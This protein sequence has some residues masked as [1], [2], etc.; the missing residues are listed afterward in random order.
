[1]NLTHSQTARILRELSVLLHAGIPV[2]EGFFLLAAEEQGALQQL[3]QSLAAEL[4]QGTPLPEALARSG[5]FPRQVSAMTAIGQATGRMEETLAS[6]A[7]YYEERHRTSRRIRQALGYPAAIGALMLVVMGVLLI[8]VLPVFDEVYA[9]L[10]S[11]LTGIAAGLLYFGQLLEAALPAL[12]VI[13]LGIIALVRFCRPL[14]ESISGWF[15][16]RFGDRWVFRKNN[17]ARFAQAMALGLGSGLPLE[18]AAVLSRELLEDIPGA[19]RRCR[20]CTDALQ[21]GAALAD[22]MEAGSLLPPHHC[23]MLAVG[24]QSGSGDRVMQQIAAQM[25][26]TARE[27]LEDA[28]GKIEPAMVLLT[29]LMVGLLLLTVM[30]PLLNILSA[31]G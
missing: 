26:E 11:R 12:L 1:M 28:V 4:D 5:S 27:A 31:I 21:Q 25:E 24:L 29:S 30:L 19:A 9:S 16:S 7:D 6:L 13:A 20:Q 8:K 2:T 17:N 10:G 3:L 22:A 18:E 23:R 14:R 15:L